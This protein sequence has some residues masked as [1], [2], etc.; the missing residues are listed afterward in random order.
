[1]KKAA[2][3]S[4]IATTTA[5]ATSKF[6]RADSIVGRRGVERE[7][8]LPIAILDGIKD[9]GRD[10]WR[11]WD[12]HFGDEVVVEGREEEEEMDDDD[13]DARGAML[14]INRTSTHKRHS[15]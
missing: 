12:Q 9:G 5:A 8:A 10:W 11:W 4:T 14:W 7:Q 2:S 6:R 13:D 1:M 15:H 3:S